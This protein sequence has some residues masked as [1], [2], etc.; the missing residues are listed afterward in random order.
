MV[1][2]AGIE[3]DGGQG[4]CV[5]RRPV[6]AEGGDRGVQALDDERELV[7]QDA[8]SPAGVWPGSCATSAC[9]LPRTQAFTAWALTCAA[10]AG[11]GYSARAI[12]NGQPRNVSGRVT[13]VRASKKARIRSRAD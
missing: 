12:R 7:G 13:S 5:L 10:E 6:A 2:T 1:M 8:A 4:A 9:N 11:S 3:D